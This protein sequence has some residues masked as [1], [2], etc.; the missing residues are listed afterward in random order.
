MIICVRTWGSRGVRA[1]VAAPIWIGQSHNLEP[2]RGI[3]QW[4]LWPHIGP[5]TMAT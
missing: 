5:G 3:E 1:A 2:G 4:Q